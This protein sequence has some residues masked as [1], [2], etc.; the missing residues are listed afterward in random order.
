MVIWDQELTSSQNIYIPGQLNKG[1]PN[2]PPA[3]E[4][5]DE[6]K[7]ILQSLLGDATTSSVLSLYDR[8]VASGQER[9]A[10]KDN[11]VQFP[12]MEREIRGK[13]HGVSCSRLPSAMAC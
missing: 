2:A 1:A 9:L 7:T 12:P 4:V 5:S 10:P 6:D 11:S 13:V 3:R 8:T